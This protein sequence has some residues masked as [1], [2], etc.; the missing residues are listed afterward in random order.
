MKT[1]TIQIGSHIHI[2]TTRSETWAV[3]SSINV[4]M[5]NKEK[6][7]HTV[8]KWY[9]IKL[10]QISVL[11]VGFLHLGSF[12]WLK[13]VRQQVFWKS[14]LMLNEI[15]F[16]HCSSFLQSWILFFVYLG[17]T[18][19]QQ[20]VKWHIAEGDEGRT[21]AELSPTLPPKADHDDLT[22]IPRPNTYL[23]LHTKIN[24][25]TT[26][27]CVGTPSNFSQN[28]Q[29][30]WSIIQDD[31]KV[32][33]SAPDMHLCWIKE[34]LIILWKAKSCLELHPQFGDAGFWCAAPAWVLNL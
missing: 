26:R 21:G 12:W 31:A 15:S 33:R 17:Q 3:R 1:N 2:S 9:F 30:Q 11:P 6:G 22:H 32:F 10:K 18:G 24:H 4:N 23:L 14:L 7:Y 27:M 20:G 29:Y 25:F 5:L 34:V 28:F 8:S 19:S 16:K 13:T